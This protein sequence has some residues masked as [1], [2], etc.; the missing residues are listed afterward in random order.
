M[1]PSPSY[2]RH[3]SLARLVDRAAVFP[4]A[5]LMTNLSLSS[6]HDFRAYYSSI[7]V[8]SLLQCALTRRNFISLTISLLPKKCSRRSRGIKSPRTFLPPRDTP[9]LGGSRFG[10]W[11]SSNLGYGRAVTPIEPEGGRHLH[12][13]SSSSP[14][15]HGQRGPPTPAP[16][17]RHAYLASLRAHRTHPSIGFCHPHPHSPR[18]STFIKRTLR[19][20]L[21]PWPA[22]PATRRL[23]R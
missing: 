14:S 9:D 3:H 18:P 23:L 2:P 15:Q 19:H 17:P 16:L 20:L 22:T 8:A 12:I 21:L 1:L 11:P 7:P 5:V 13:H 10:T 6:S 4:F